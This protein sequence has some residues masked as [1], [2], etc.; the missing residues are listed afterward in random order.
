M[1]DRRPRRFGFTLIELLVVIAIIAVLIGLLVPAVQQVRESANRTQCQNN[2]KQIGLS[3]NNF[4]DQHKVFPPGALRSPA[5]GTVGPFFRRFGVTA[6]GVNHSWAVFVLPYLEQSALRARYNLNADWASPINQAARETPVPLFLCPSAPG[7]SPRYNVSSVRAAGTDYAPDNAYGAALE[8]AGLVDVS[9]DRNGILQVNKA[10]SIPEIQDGTS[11]TFL[12]SECAGRP[13]EWRA[14]ALAIVNGQTDGGWA[15]HNNEY[16][17]RPV[18][19]QLQQQQ[20]GLQLPPGGRPPRVR[21]RVGPVHPGRHGH[22][23]V[24]AADHP[25][26][27]RGRPDR[28]LTPPEVPP[29]EPW[30]SSSP[31]WPWRRPPVAGA[32]TAESRSTRSPGSSA[33]PASRPPAS[34][35]TSPRPAP[36]RS[37]TSR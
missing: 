20:R 5:K 17:T 8:S 21:G 9:V 11:N 12:V 34:R 14:G 27:R 35:C 2:L 30:A 29:C 22:P 36:P 1:D 19:H 10:W 3:L 33:T 18:P 16:I 25:Q 6:N 28:L 37:R 24:R 32:A 15:D 26:W 13:D 31:P 4:H 7:A 23:P